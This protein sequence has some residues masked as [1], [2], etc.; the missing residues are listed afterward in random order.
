MYAVALRYRLRDASSEGHQALNDAVAGEVAA[1]AGLISTTLLT[2]GA[3][4]RFCNVY[5]FDSQTACERFRTGSVPRRIEAHPNVL[6]LSAGA[7][8]LEPATATPATPP[9]GRASAALKP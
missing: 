6:E 8:P 3:P 9:P 1:A 7:Y 5:L 2:D 4:G